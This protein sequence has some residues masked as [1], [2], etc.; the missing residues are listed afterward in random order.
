MADDTFHINFIELV[1]RLEWHRKTAAEVDAD[2]EFMI[3]MSLEIY[4]N[5]RRPPGPRPL[6]DAAMSGRKP[7]P[8]R[9]QEPAILFGAYGLCSRSPQE[10][11]KQ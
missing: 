8:P 6:R 3:L 4:M 7:P 5:G 11:T 9:P 1:D 2:V 10:A